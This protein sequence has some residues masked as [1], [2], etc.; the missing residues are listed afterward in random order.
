MFIGKIIANIIIQKENKKI[1]CHQKSQPR[2]RSPAR[3]RR[4]ARMEAVYIH[5]KC[6][7]VTHVSNHVFPVYQTENVPNARASGPVK[8]VDSAIMIP[9]LN[10]K[11]E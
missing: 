1:I 5:P 9:F 8:T 7:N 6:V 11:T 4:V 3:A 10:N 2:I